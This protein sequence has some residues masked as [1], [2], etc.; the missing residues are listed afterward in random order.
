MNFDSMGTGK[1]RWRIAA[2]ALV[3]SVLSAGC[4]NG[5]GEAPSGQNASNGPAKPNGPLFDECAG[6]SPEEVAQKL[7]ASGARV[8]FRNSVSCQWI[9]GGSTV[10]TFTMYRGSPIGRERQ[11]E[12]RTRNDVKDITVRGHSAFLIQMDGL[13]EIAVDFGNDFIEWSVELG[14]V[15]DNPGTCDSTRQLAEL[16]IDRVQK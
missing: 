7:N 9:V 12:D 8:Q 2:V 1:R 3:G 14:R 15:V 4:S 11:W 6:L 13:C 10:A 16:T 5:G